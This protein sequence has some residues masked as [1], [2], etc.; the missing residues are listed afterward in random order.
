MIQLAPLPSS[1][2]ALIPANQTPAL[3][4]ASGDRAEQRFW[5]FFTVTIRNPNTRMA[6]ARAAREFCDFVTAGGVPALPDVQPIHVA[7]YVEA[8]GKTHAPSTVKLRLAAVRM[9]FDWLVTGQVIASNPAISVKGP[10]YVVRR[11][12]TPVLERGEAKRLLDSLDTKSLIGLRDRAFIGLLIYTFPRVGA[13]VAMQVQDFYP[14]GLRGWV[15]LH[16][17][18]GKLHELPCHHNLEAWLHD[19][20][21]A[22]GIG[23][24]KKTPLFRSAIGRSGRLSE[25]GLVERNAL[26]LVQRKAR[27]AG[28]TTA[29]CN[30]TFRATGITAYMQNGGTLEKAQAIAAHESPRTTKL[31]DRTADQITLDEVERIVL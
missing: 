2:H 31:Y 12:K 9:L 6:Y 18:G 15:R 17:K 21:A 4:T 22:A 1:A 8:L 19:Y 7:A 14:I 24:K 13:A 23:D 20:V 11:G 5:E 29:I 28:V 27:Q 3:M 10:K 26:D 30:H 25:R 16:E